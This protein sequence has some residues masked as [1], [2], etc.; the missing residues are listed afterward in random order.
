MQRSW[1]DENVWNEERR[2][3]RHAHAVLLEAEPFLGDKM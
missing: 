1:S 3:E 2:L